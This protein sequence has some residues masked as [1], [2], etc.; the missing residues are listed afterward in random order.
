MD[1]ILISNSFPF[2]LIRRE[3]H[4]I[5]EPLEKLKDILSS[6][7]FVSAWGHANTMRSANALLGTD[8][9]PKTERPAIGISPEGFPSL[10]GIVFSECWHLSPNYIPGFRPQI[11]QEVSPEQ[12]V[13]WQTL[14]L[15]WV[16]SP[17]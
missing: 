9:T 17:E 7:P 5:P 10:D 6:R 13:G 1:T 16:N 2:S 4:V 14:C 3:V 12:I 8:L 11:N 15:R